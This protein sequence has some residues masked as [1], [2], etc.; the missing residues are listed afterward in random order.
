MNTTYF[1]DSKK[2]FKAI[3]ITLI[4]CCVIPLTIY[5][6]V[7][8]SSPAQFFNR[9]MGQKLNAL[10]DN[11]DRLSLGLDGILP[12]SAEG[13]RKKLFPP[14]D[15]QV[16]TDALTSI[17]DDC[18]ALRETEKTGLDTD[19]LPAYAKQR[20][21]VAQACSS[22][23]R[24]VARSAFTYGQFRSIATLQH[25]Y[26]DAAAAQVE[27]ERKQARGVDSKE[28]QKADTARRNMLALQNWREDVD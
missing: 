15:V 11:W 28:K 13:A 3:W 10:T 6:E 22:M 8:H 18:N 21:E 7:N 16:S 12:I 20:D 2:G 26:Y 9:S 17:Y 24:L 27:M 5:L 23:A 14:E 1:A 4:V 25:T 19:L